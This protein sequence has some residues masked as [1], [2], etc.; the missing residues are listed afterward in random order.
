MGAT[1][2]LVNYYADLLILQYL[3][4]AKAY[5]TIQTLAT[6]TILPQTT[7][8]TIVFSLAPTSGTFVLSW[9]GIATTAINWND[10]AAI[11]Q[12]ALRLITGLSSITV[13][14]SIASLTLTITFTDVPPI[15]PLLVLGSSSLV[16]GPTV[17]TSSIDQ[18]DAT[19]PLAVQNAFNLIGP[20]FAQGVQLDILGKYVGAFRTG[21][22]NGLPITL[23]D[24]DFLSLIQFAIIRNRAESSLATIQDLLFQFFPG[25]VLV[26]DYANMQMSYLIS[27]AI[28]SQDLVRLL[29]QEG[30]LPKPMA[31]ALAVVVYAPVVTTFFGFRTYDLPA[32]NSKPFNTYDV[33]DTSSPWL[34][35][36]NTI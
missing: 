28:G 5:A 22:V 29:V 17:V 9:N 33:Y 36:S 35:Y 15:A 12:T 26:F 25:E 7:V 23:S 11:I 34:S 1:Q 4:K 13:M 20:D 24:A 32:A 18:I 30:L 10:S 16:N 8:Q 6:P 31:V 21:T 19:L 27:S 14:G 3:Q 2:A